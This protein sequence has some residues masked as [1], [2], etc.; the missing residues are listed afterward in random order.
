MKITKRQL[1][2]VIKE[3]T[4][5]LLE[6]G[7]LDWATERDWEQGWED[8]R[9]GAFGEEEEDIDRSR[10]EAETASMRR[11]AG[12]SH[13][14]LP[15]T[16]PKAAEDD[17]FRLQQL[18]DDIVWDVGELAMKDPRFKYHKRAAEYLAGLFD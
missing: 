15:R 9:R 17:A 8:L 3:E 5:K 16:S 18:V 13:R 4:T 6:E 12:R 10:H 14:A 2:Q 7:W 1:R 11:G